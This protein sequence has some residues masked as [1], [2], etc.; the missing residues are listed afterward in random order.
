MAKFVKWI[1]GVLGWSLGGPV[2]G[3]IGFAIG[4]LLD[5]SEINTAT[6]SQNSFSSGTTPGDFT[7]SFLVLSAAVMKAD[8]K[9]L[10]SEFNYVN[11]FLIN[12]FGEEK[13]KALLPFLYEVLKKDI[14]VNDVCGQICEHMP[15]SARLQLL[16]YL[17]GIA[18]ADGQ[19]H[20]L[21]TKI[22]LE[23]AEKLLI[24][25]LDAVSIESMYHK[26]TIADYKILEV[27]ETATN[28]ELKKAYRKMALK[29][30]PDKVDG[31]GED[32]KKA[33]E[34]KFKRLQQAYDNIK[35]YRDIN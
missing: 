34:E 4:S 1:G 14:P 9:T 22:I 5:N 25:K 27:E 33:A 6:N 2:G 19:I 11:K 32:V 26:D 16:H 18:Y 12:N 21:E 15:H 3:L 35:K 23:I 20:P 24:S 7:V 28:E 13:T 30:H 10:Q 8:G 17:Y 31:M 29:Y